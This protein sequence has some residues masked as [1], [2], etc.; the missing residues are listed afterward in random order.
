MDELTEVRLA[1]LSNYSSQGMTHGTYLLGLAIGF[2]AWVEQ[3]N[4][5]TH[6]VWV[7]GLSLILMGVFYIAMRA[8]YWNYLSTMVVS[9][10]YF[11]DEGRISYAKMKENIDKSTYITDEHK[12]RIKADIDY[13]E[14]LPDVLVRVQASV[15]PSFNRNATN[16]PSIPFRFLIWTHERHRNILIALSLFLGL[17]FCLSYFL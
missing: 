7:A 11:I 10:G 16:K 15:S 5:V 9:I 12:A 8:V 4:A 13:V 3:A 1:L 2:F 6:L 14:R 17:T